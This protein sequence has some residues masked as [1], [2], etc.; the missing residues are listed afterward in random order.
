MRLIFSAILLTF[1]ITGYTQYIDTGASYSEDSDEFKAATVWAGATHTSGFG[2]KV[3]YTHYSDPQINTDSSLLQLTYTNYNAQGAIGFRNIDFGSKTIL[4]ADTEVNIV[5]T[6]S[7][8]LGIYAI[9]D[10]VDSTRSI[11]TGTRYVNTSAGI[12]WLISENLNF[13][14]LLGNTYFTDDNNRPFIRSKLI[15]TFVPEYGIST[16]IRTKNQ[17]DTNPGSLNYFSP[18]TLS[19]QAIGFQIRK[20]YDKLMYLAVV[21]YGSE[22]ISTSWED[23]RNSIGLWS[24]GVQTRPLKKTGITFGV[25]VTNSINSSVDSYNWIGL[26][27]WMK[28]PL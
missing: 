24:L 9:T 18:E 27:S 21:E 20:S 16:Y 26:T 2:A 19:Q 11:Q 17:K 25:S 7:V 15:W 22:Q 14:L 5:L 12:D 4:V 28:I 3:G 23:S 8:T 6:D 1:S 10:I 13:N